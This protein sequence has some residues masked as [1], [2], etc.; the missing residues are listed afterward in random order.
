M[1][2]QGSSMINTTLITVLLV[3]FFAL[4]II[5]LIIGVRRYRKRA[6]HKPKR[7]ALSVSLMTT[8]SFQFEVKTQLHSVDNWQN[9][10]DIGSPN[11]NI[12]TSSLVSKDN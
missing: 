6:E 4:V 7:Y 12:I 10:T 9:V 3:A 2:F 1:L 8:N 5:L 11:E